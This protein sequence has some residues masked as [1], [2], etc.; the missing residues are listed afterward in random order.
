MQLDPSHW[1][2]NNVLQF[3]Q[4][5]SKEFQLPLN[6]TLFQGISGPQLCSFNVQQFQSLAKDSGPILYNF[7]QK[8]KATAQC[9]HIII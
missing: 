8:L 7:V 9:N 6:M 5:C 2:E 3:A 1:S 4:W